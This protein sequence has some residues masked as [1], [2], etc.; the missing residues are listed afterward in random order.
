MKLGMG[1]RLRAEQNT[2]IE[3]KQ[4][5]IGSRR[6]VLRRPRIRHPRFRRRR[7]VHD[8]SDGP[9]ARL[10]PAHFGRLFRPESARDR[11]GPRKGGRAA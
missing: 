11:A 10:I 1:G 8:L 3:H 5:A 4:N 7:G 2:N 9:A 6:H